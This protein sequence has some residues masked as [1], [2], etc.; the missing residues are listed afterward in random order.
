MQPAHRWP[1]ATPRHDQGVGRWGHVVL[2]PCIHK[3]GRYLEAAKPQSFIILFMPQ[4]PLMCLVAQSWKSGGYPLRASPLA[5]QSTWSKSVDSSF[6]GRPGF[7][8]FG[9]VVMEGQAEYVVV[10]SI[11][12]IRCHLGVRNP[13]SP[14]FMG[15]DS[16]AWREI[17]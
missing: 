16:G 2:F 13:A 15:C 10:D 17:G 12:W 6:G 11:S 4:K 5:A 14:P 3:R 1:L 7:C 8:L 9:K